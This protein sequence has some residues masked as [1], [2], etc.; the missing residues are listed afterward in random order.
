MNTN[1][2]NKKMGFKNEVSIT[3]QGEQTSPLFSTDYIQGIMRTAIGYYIICDFLIG[4]QQIITKKGY[5]VKSGINFFTLY[6]PEQNVYIVCDMYSVKFVYF[7]EF[8]DMSHVVNFDDQFLNNNQ[9]N[10]NNNQP[11]MNNNQR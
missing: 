7:T 3:Q 6:D 9:Q 4:T 8:K 11:T 2:N 10:I 5:L 1:M